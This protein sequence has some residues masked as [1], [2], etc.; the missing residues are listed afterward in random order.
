MT[1]RLEQIEEELKSIGGS[2]VKGVRNN[3]VKTASA[4][5]KKQN[6]IKNSQR[7]QQEEDDEDEDED[8]SDE[9]D[10]DND[11]EDDEA[12]SDDSDS[13]VS[14]LKEGVT[15]TKNTPRGQ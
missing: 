3:G 11:D 8:E 1:G 14:A 6:S 15:E 9:D 5:V 10:S 4:D 7:K 2:G 13:G 12:S